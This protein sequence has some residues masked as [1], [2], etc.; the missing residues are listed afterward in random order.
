MDSQLS[1]IPEDFYSFETGQPFESC[2]VCKA[3]LLAGDV[4]YFVEKAIRNYHEHDVKDVVYEYAICWHCAHDMNGQMSEESMRSIQQYFT[5]QDLFMKN[6]QEHNSKDLSEAESAIP[7][8]C[9]I[10]GQAVEK[11]DEYMIYGHFRGN[12]MVKSTMP[13]LMSGSVMDDVSDLLSNETTDQLDDFMGE[14]F[15]G[16]P[17]LEELWKTR[18]PVFF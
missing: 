17:E 13:Y 6:I 16:P 2:L 10:T 18:R 1:S 5:R 14:Y 11:L 15:G 3:D 8:H 7:D 4:D 9:V 12:K